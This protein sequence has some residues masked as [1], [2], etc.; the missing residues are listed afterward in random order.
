MKRFRRYLIGLAALILTA[1]LLAWAARA[2][3]SSRRG[4]ELVAGRL[5]TLFGT[6]V[7]VAEVDVGLWAS[8]LR[9]L[10][11]YESGSDARTGEPWAVVEEVEADVS[12]LDLARGE[13][14]PRQL[15][16]RGIALTL[17]LDEEG[18]LL[19]R[20]PRHGVGSAHFP[21][22][23]LT[24]ARVTLQ[25][26]KRPALT[27]VGVEGELHAEGSRL[28]LRGTVADP[29][30]GMWTLEG[31]Y[32]SPGGVG[33]ATLKTVKPIR[34]TQAQLEGLP[35][36]PPGVWEQVKAEGMTSAEITVRSDPDRPDL[37]YRVALEPFETR[38]T[39]PSIDLDA[40]EARG[41]VIIEDHVVHLRDVRGKVAGGKLEVSA[42]LNFRDAHD[43]LDFL[44]TARGL[45]VRRLPKSWQLPPQIEGRLNGRAEMYLTLLDGEVHTRGSGEG[46]IADGRFAGL[47][48]RT[49]RLRLH[50]DG[51]GFRFRTAP[52]AAAAP[53]GVP[54][55]LAVALQAPSPGQDGKTP[56][57]A[58]F[59]A[60]PGRLAAGLT[61][62]VNATIRT[63][64][65]AT[66][67]AADWLEHGRKVD[68]KAEPSYLEMN[69]G[70]DD[71]DVEQL[72]SG[73]GLK[74]PFR[75]AG[76]LSFEV[77]AA[78]PLD[79]PR[80]LKTYRFTG[81]ATLPHLT[82][83]GLRLE[84]VRA[85]VAYR[86]GV[87]RLEDLQGRVPDGQPE[88][89]K[90]A[91]LPAGRF[92]G[93]AQ[94]QLIPQGDLTA[95]LALDR[96]PLARVL[97]L[98]PGAAEAASGAASAT[99]SLR[100][101]ADRLGD[102]SAWEASG[103]LTAPHLR[104][105]GLA[106]KDARLE[107]R[108]E[109]GVAT[110]TEVRGRLEGADVAGAAE[111]RLAGTYPFTAK[112]DLEFLDLAS[113][114][115]LA[116]GL[117]PPFALAGRFRSTAE[118]KGTLS[119]LAF[120]AA[121]TGEA[122]NLRVE[123]LNLGKVAF[124]WGGGADVLR[125][126]D[127]RANLHGGEVTG[128][129]AVPLRP[130]AAG[131][132]DL[133]FAKLDV[134]ALT[135]DLPAMPFP[136]EG[137]AD[138]TV[139]GTFPP[140]GPTGEREFA[141]KVELA[142]PRLRVRGIPTERLTG[143]VNYQ[144]RV[145][146]Y[147][148]EGEALGGRFQLDGKVPL[149]PAKPVEQPAK[150]DGEGRFRLE[151]VRLSRLWEALDVQ[152][153]LGPLEGAVDL[154][155][156]FRHEGPAAALVG[157]G[158]F[159]VESLRWGQTPLARNIRGEVRLTEKEVRLRD[160]TGTLGQGLVRGQV[161][162]SLRREGRS[163]FT[164]DLSRVEAGQL[165]A[166]WPAL[167]GVAQGPL[168]V[169]LRGSVGREWTG[170][171]EVTLTRGRVLGAEV[172]ELRLPLTWSV[173]PARGRGQLD[174]RDATAQVALGRAAGRA[175]FRWGAGNR[176]EGQLRFSDVQLRTLL[177]Q[178]TD[179]TSFGNGQ[180]T[181]RIDFAGTDVR[182]LDDLTATMD[183]SLAR[184]QAFEFPVLRQL[185]PFLGVGRSTSAT[186]DRGKLQARLARGIVRVEGLSLV[187]ASLQ[188]FL[189]GTVTLQGRLDLDVLANTGRVGVNPNL[190]DLL[191][192]G[193]PAV[194]PI[195]AEVILRASDYFSNRLLRLRVGGTIRSPSVRIDPVTLLTDEAIR[196]FL[197]RA[198]LPLVR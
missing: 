179:L 47:P 151:Q 99:V 11:I 163:W 88:P 39:I 43:R 148:F 133:R 74:L 192:L 1:C 96:I 183:A 6:S 142:A 12:A 8:S 105:Y 130:A 48:A 29:Q 19:S 187:G 159:A 81:T 82:L 136:V 98:V 65:R 86:D 162:F 32:D 93:T 182:S 46:D 70:L 120:T 50:A 168:D 80:D 122:E 66:A 4:T 53:A 67:A 141:A 33:H 169:R 115:R 95:R 160:L 59:F 2:Y 77:R 107:L 84:Q 144:A 64:S 42:D 87:L 195:P 41:Q 21:R 185:L 68:P 56:S 9:R 197:N 127:L 7:Q 181:G 149:A 135:A 131:S 100:A 155:V 20:L 102:V 191:G 60:W 167:A 55:L 112:L 194:G 79:T 158:R 34:V 73:L 173:V 186:F 172:A 31:A 111:L 89:A 171:G 61:A 116:A 25:Q 106:L 132:L 22:I 143:T 178:V 113:L 118:V 174:V 126:T 71:V 5:G 3:L 180:V 114:E 184:T 121:G 138:G 18:R 30:W 175:S 153:A 166:P 110:A 57:S 58:G 101:P 35:L 91:D 188:L 92:E 38:V 190:L 125:L 146:A 15:T 94:L 90:A 104:A 140:V 170:S 128:S 164:L 161:A 78:V 54:I 119:P 139:R 51:K 150:S 177:R 40:E 62:G 45:D 13:T 23:Q 165:L 28:I 154:D 147:R 37:H 189:E 123:K 76:R 63:A 49:M 85:R 157:S 176:L 24:D 69:L 72:V 156:T 109:R 129:A 10:H 83:E 36:V 145:V 44:V 16:L 124:R 27:V 103:I 75:A 26:A 152:A 108:L 196:F 14:V 193:L 198:N 97:T 52:P 134:S 117:R 17:R 137:R